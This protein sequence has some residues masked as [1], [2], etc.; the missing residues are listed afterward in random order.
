MNTL[1]K[2]CF[3]IPLIPA[4]GGW[5]TN[6]RNSHWWLCGISDIAFNAS[7]WWFSFINRT[8]P[9]TSTVRNADGKYIGL[10]QK[11]SKRP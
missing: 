5:F 10:V 8:T 9:G 7:D 11:P 2:L 3:A 6:R 4:L 1:L